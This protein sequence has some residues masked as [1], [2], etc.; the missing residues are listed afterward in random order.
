MIFQLAHC[1]DV[2]TMHDADAPRRGD[3]FAIHQMRTT[4][5]IASP[6]PVLG[7][8]FRWVVGGLDHQ[9]EHHLAPRLPHTLYPRTAARFRAACRDHGVTYHLHPGV[10][11][12][13]RSHGRHLRLMSRPN[14]QSVR[15][16]TGP[17]TQRPADVGGPRTTAR[18][19]HGRRSRTIG[20]SWV[21]EHETPLGPGRSGHHG[22]LTLRDPFFTLSPN[23]I[24]ARGAPF[25]GCQDAG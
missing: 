1:V 13:L 19:R 24:P 2:T 8:V 16:P 4:A 25:G 17:A 12:A 23:R 6:I 5:D 21:A 14:A 20:P 9:I 7:H 11:S 10:W 22:S 18:T 3:D 15:D